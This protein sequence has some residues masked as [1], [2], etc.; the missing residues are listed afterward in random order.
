MSQAN[1]EVMRAAIEAFNR[2]DGEG[3]GAFLSNE[4]EIVPVQAA[5]EGTVH[6][7]SERRQ[8]VLRRC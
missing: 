8:A 7:G 2:C 5:L 4:A 3:F 1:V 6:P